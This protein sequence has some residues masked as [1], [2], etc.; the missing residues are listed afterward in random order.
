[1]NPQE[2]HTRRIVQSL[3]LLFCIGG[4]FAWG[5]ATRAWAQATSAPAILQMF[6]ARWNTVENRMADIFDVGYGKMWLPPPTR[7][8]PSGSNVGYEVWDRFDLG[9]PGNPTLYGTE[10]GLK[11]A[12]AAG[13]TAAMQM[14][15]DLVPNHNGRMNQNTAGFAAQGGYN[16]FALSVSG[17]PYG[18]FHN[19]SITTDTNLTNGSLLNLID[20]AQE[21]TYT[22]IRQP[23]EA[24]NPN[25]IPAGTIYNIP[26]PNNAR[27]YPD[28]GLG[29]LDL[30]DP[31]LG[32]QITRYNFNLATPLAGDSTM[33]TA[34]QLLM[35]N[36][37]WMV[38]VIGTDGFRVDSSRTMPLGVHLHLDQ[39]AFRAN[40]RLQLDGSI[41]PVFFMGEVYDANKG[42]VQFLIR[43][44]LPNPNAISPSDTTV[45]HNRDA[46]DFPLYFPLVAGLSNSNSSN[47]WA[48]IRAASV[49]TNDRAAGTPVWATDGSQGVAFVQNHDL[50]APFLVNV[51]YAYTLMRPGNAVV[52][53]NAREFG[54]NRSF[55]RSG[56]TDALGGFFGETITT[57]VDLRNTHGSGDF[58]ERSTST[59]VYVYERENSAI[60]GL[61]NRTGSSA[62]GT[63][64]DTRPN[65]QTAFAPGTVL[66]ELTGNAAN[67]TVDPGNVVPEAIR[68]DANGQINM[69]VPRN[70]THGLGYVIYG[71]AGP[72]GTLSLDGTSGVLAG[73]IPTSANNGTA[74]QSSLDI[75]SGDSF[76]LRLN[77][78]PVMLPTPA[79]ES[80][81]V[82][83]VHA[84]GDTAMFKIDGGLD[85]NNSLGVDDV[86]PGSMTYGF[87]N[88]TS[89]RTPG[90]INTGSG[91]VGTGHGLYEQTIDTT[92]LD[93]GPHYVTVRAFRHRDAATAGDGGP[94]VFTDF[95]RTIYVDRLPPEAAV[96]SFAPTA[97]DPNDRTIIVGSVDET[98]NNMHFFLDL[99]ATVTDAEVRQMALNGQGT[100]SAYDR[101][102]W[103]LAFNS[104]KTGNHVVTVVTF[105]STFDGTR[106]FNVQ[107]LPG[108]FTQTNLGLGFGDLSGDNQLEIDGHE[109]QRWL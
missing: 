87:E 27:F 8:G 105:E 12:I 25:N 62:E 89:T 98:A 101:T 17:D 55:P 11:G 79:G 23:V 1:M 19:P 94:A 43:K 33:E 31:I 52:Y 48:N 99:P 29:G 38:E 58:Q 90:Y 53:L 15:T 18:D 60:V 77:T 28:Q 92:Q 76:T 56:K 82:R 93:E 41:Q 9:A 2:I 78:T 49:D 61:N 30:T 24:D 64:S 63:G 84:D 44:D 46:L 20:I 37:Q 32:E 45:A 51:A 34:M 96:I 68:V 39:A 74:R 81:P 36:V 85:L 65:I 40:P 5:G 54:N 108:L 104:V 14:Y 88:F 47:N 10:A 97:T 6:E 50:N 66:I 102:Q 16:G 106:G 109:R 107:R 67:A 69:V 26:N 72:Q 57:L 100:A 103:N 35:R 80:N 7:A 22:F 73:T 13:H 42:I 59:E 21:K 75:V 91:N 95:R 83:D 3:T 70:G 71:V 86:T 4:Q